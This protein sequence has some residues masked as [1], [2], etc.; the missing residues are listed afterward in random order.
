MKYGVMVRML[1]TK[2]DKSGFEEQERGPAVV[3]PCH[4]RDDAG[5]LLAGIQRTDMGKRSSQI[6]VQVYDAN[7]RPVWLTEAMVDTIWREIDKEQEPDLPKP[8]DVKNKLRLTGFGTHNDG[9]NDDDRAV[10]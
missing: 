6:V 4:D 8:T 2:L 3:I 9:D 7:D 1:F 5:A 10:G